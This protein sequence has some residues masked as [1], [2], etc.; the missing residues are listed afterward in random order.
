MHNSGF[1]PIGLLLICGVAVAAADDRYVAVDQAHTGDYWK[2]MHDR[3]PAPK[4][5][6]AAI[7]R[8]ASGCAAVAF[9][10]KGDGTV[11]EPKL[12]R[13]FATRDGVDAQFGQAAM[14]NVPAWHYV[15]AAG[16]SQ[17]TAVYTYAILTFFLSGTREDEMKEQCVIDDFVD[18]L[19]GP[20]PK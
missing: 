18:A 8:H 11:A 6:A 7:K 17:R 9:A 12:V 4:Y 10:I 3:H 13:T 15:P 14:A 2:I 1:V 16:N 5:P 20:T 19:R